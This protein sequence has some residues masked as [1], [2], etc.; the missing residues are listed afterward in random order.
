MILFFLGLAHISM[1]VSTTEWQKEDWLRQIDMHC[2]VLPPGVCQFVQCT[3]WHMHGFAY[4]VNAQKMK[5]I[6]ASSPDRQVSTSLHF[7][8]DESTRFLFQRNVA[9]LTEVLLL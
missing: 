2:T 5:Q 4:Y 9:V 7:L 1:Q 8:L 6:F 3:M